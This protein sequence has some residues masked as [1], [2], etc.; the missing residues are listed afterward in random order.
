[1][2][3]K[4]YKNRRKARGQ[5]GSE[6]S[7]KFLEKFMNIFTL[8]YEHLTH[9]QPI[10]SNIGNLQSPNMNIEE[11]LRT[12]SSKLKHTSSIHHQISTNQ[13]QDIP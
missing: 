8:V 2:N 11:H 13:H 12:Y 6:S 3:T 4:N 7:G 10:P 5:P 1:M 9:I